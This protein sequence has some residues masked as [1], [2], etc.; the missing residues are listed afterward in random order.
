MIY[1]ATHLVQRSEA[2][3]QWDFRN[4]KYIGNNINDSVMAGIGQVVQ[5]KNQQ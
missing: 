2:G 4:I 3:R 1:K 5:C